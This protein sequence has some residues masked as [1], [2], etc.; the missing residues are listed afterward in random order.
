MLGEILRRNREDQKLSLT[1][2]ST[3][4]NI[5]VRYLEALEN[6]QYKKLPA[7]VYV[8][9]FLKLYGNLLA[10]DVQEL[11]SL[12]H[13]ECNAL[14]IT[15]A[16]NYAA[17]TRQGFFSRF[18]HFVILPRLIR[19]LILL[20][21]ILIFLGYIGFG[22]YNIFRAPYLEVYYPQDNTIVENSSFEVVGKTETDVQLF[23]ND[24][25][26]LPEGNGDF[27]MSVNLQKGINSIKILV[28]NRHNKESVITRSVMFQELSKDISQ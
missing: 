28:R 13:E 15:Q 25:M 4:I 17:T 19:S 8:R 23:I 16:V 7:D 9:C 22:V 14:G 18:Y 11:L 1:Q 20:I 24:A 27:H 10:L 21:C 26:S 12:F 2:V 3:A 6:E 5:P